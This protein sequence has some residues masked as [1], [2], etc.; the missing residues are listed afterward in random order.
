MFGTKSLAHQAGHVGAYHSSAF[1]EPHFDQNGNPL[2]LRKERQESLRDAGIKVSN[3][4]SE[5]DPSPRPDR[6]QVFVSRA[7][8]G[9]FPVEGLYNNLLFGTPIQQRRA[10]EQQ[11]KEDLADELKRHKLDN[12]MM[13]SNKDG[14]FKDRSSALKKAP[15]AGLFGHLLFGSST[16]RDVD[17]KA[18]ALHDNGMIVDDHVM[19]DSRL[20]SS[21]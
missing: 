14:L 1:G 6:G 7:A 5:I 9:S 18:A 21:F 16:K 4:L 10:R 13:V 20:T 3:H 19:V 15:N 8:K 12:E 17:P 11:R 2:P